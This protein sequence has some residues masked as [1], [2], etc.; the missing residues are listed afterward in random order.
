MVAGYDNLLSVW[1]SS[2]PVE[3]VRDLPLGSHGG[4]VAGMN[5]DIAN[6]NREGLMKVSVGDANDAHRLHLLLG[7][8]A[9][10]VVQSQQQGVARLPAKGC[11]NLVGECQAS[12]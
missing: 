2:D 10:V 4:S 1:L 9:P 3:P 7:R 11:Q 8:E 5:E 6:W 12:A